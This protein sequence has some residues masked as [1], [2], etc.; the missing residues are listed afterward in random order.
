MIL[1]KIT[2]SDLNGNKVN[3][4]TTSEDEIRVDLSDIESGTYCLNMVGSS[5]AP[6][7]MSNQ[8]IMIRNN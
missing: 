7:L 4:K 5:I 6:E 2:L 1:R 8:R 3:F